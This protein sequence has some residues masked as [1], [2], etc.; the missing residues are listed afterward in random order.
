LAAHDFN[1]W[2]H[3]KQMSFNVEY[4]LQRASHW[5]QESG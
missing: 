2:N 3:C 1:P 5:L 4:M